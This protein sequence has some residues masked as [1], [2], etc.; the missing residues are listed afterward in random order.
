MRPIVIS[1]AT[2]DIALRKIL[3]ARMQVFICEFSYLIQSRTGSESEWDETV[4]I[5]EPVTKL[6]YI[7]I[8]MLVYIIMSWEVMKF[9]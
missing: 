9:I 5:F 7:V 1:W 4:I 2:N 8:N 6:R 3:V